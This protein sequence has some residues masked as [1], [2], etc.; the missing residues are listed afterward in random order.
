[1]LDIGVLIEYLKDD[2]DQDKHES[3]QDLLELHAQGKAELQ[4]S[5]RIRD[6]VPDDPWA[7]QLTELLNQLDISTPEE[8][9]ENASIG[10]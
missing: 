4:V 5:A 1:M 7:R 2:N 9:L 3:V 6:D 10:S 8:Y